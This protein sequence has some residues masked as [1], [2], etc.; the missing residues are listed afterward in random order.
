MTS[1]KDRLIRGELGNLTALAEIIEDKK[2]SFTDAIDLLKNQSHLIK[3]DI[4][5]RRYC[6]RTAGG[7]E[8]MIDESYGRIKMEVRYSFQPYMPKKDVE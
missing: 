5:N 7:T 4:G 3:D 6:F 8:L 2:M 1:L